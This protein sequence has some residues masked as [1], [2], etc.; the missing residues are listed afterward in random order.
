M[1]DQEI[2]N[3]NETEELD[4]QD[5]IEETACE[6]CDSGNALGVVMVFAAGAVAGVIARNLVKRAGPMIQAW[7]DKRAARKAEKT[8]PDESDASDSDASEDSVAK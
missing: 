2:M 4:T 6:E 3:V 1:N 5:C 7:K 8:Q